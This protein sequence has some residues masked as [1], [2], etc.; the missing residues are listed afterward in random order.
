MQ[1]YLAKGKDTARSKDSSVIEKKAQNE[2]NVSIGD[3]E[4]P[5]A[6]V[7]SLTEAE[8]EEKFT[9]F[10]AIFE[11]FKVLVLHKVAQEIIRREM[12]DELKIENNELLGHEYEIL[13][14]IDEEFPHVEM[15]VIS[16]IAKGIDVFHIEMY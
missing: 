7:E 16:A 2:S 14:K 12:L 9:V 11:E 3:L 13:R 6:K 5:V 8:I 15:G 4:Q 10:P 1:F